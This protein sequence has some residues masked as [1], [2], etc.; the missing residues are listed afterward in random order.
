[1]RAQTYL[2]SWYIGIAVSALL[3]ALLF[4]L[5]SLAQKS[6]SQ[7]MTSTGK[8]SGPSS[9]DDPLNDLG[10][11]V[12]ADGVWL[13]DDGGREYF[14]K[15]LPKLKGTYQWIDDT[16]T[17]IKYK[18]WYNFE[19]LRHDDENLYLKLY[20]PAVVPKLP[21]R[22]ER[23]AQR[24]KDLEALAQTYL[25]EAGSGDRLYFDTFDEGLPKRGMWR[26]GFDVAD[27]NGDGHLDI[28]HGP[29]RKGIPVP[30][31]FLGNSQGQWRV[32]NEA[33]FPRAP[34]DYGDAAA[35][36]FN[37]DGLLDIAF[38]F[39]LRGLLVVVQET[40]GTF[41]IASEGLDLEIPGQGGDASGFSTRA[42]EIVDWNSDG[43][44]DILALGEGPRPAGSKDG[45]VMGVITSYAY[46][47]V[48]YEN[49]GEGKWMRRDQGLQR[50]GVF[51]DSLTTG[52]FN[53][54]GRL[55]FLT[56]SHVL[57]RR[58][59]LNLGQPDN[60]WQ[61]LSV[62]PVRRF[63]LV[64]AVTA[65]DFDGDGRD[66]MVLTY[67][68]VEMK[69]RRAGLDLFLNKGEEGWERHT[70]AV[71]EGRRS[72]WALDS[73]DLDGDGNLDLVA[74]SSDAEVWVFLGDGKGGF[75]LE[76]SPEISTPRGCRG[77][78]IRLEDLDGDGK[79]EVLGSFAGEGSAL[80][81]P[82]FPVHC[83]SGGEIA[84]W[85]PRQQEDAASQQVM[86]DREAA[87]GL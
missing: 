54:D 36:D 86:L 69:V 51:G 84:V 42:I 29:A 47:G 55:D 58:D 63:A 60:S 50:N 61:T 70:I 46:G 14:V 4:P 27:M 59:V 19:V 52:D 74:S 30:R 31:V 76:E 49:L 57:N 20:K 11:L 37:G 75:D 73:G 87:S 32:W 3:V 65:G 72:L 1:M 35:G 7:V 5:Q 28:I 9:D 48:I 64:Q 6:S 68:S 44:P 77:Y 18:R 79:D 85:K 13:K 82:Q 33:K 8:I 83:T 17:S 39:H 80:P 81:L 26:N 78:A 23:E 67:S 2:L 10:S 43:R 38:G 66:D 24:I 56:A 21:T 25:P 16:Q 62:D 34:W 22:E 41:V 53:S 71:E 45:K 12:P 15:P 40:P